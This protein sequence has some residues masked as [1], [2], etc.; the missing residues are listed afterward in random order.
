[1]SSSDVRASGTC[2]A[3]VAVWHT[4][5]PRPAA[6]APTTT[7]RTCG[8][9]GRVGGESVQASG[10]SAVASAAESA[11]RTQRETHGFRRPPCPPRSPRCPPPAPTVAEAARTRCRRCAPTLRRLRARARRRSARSTRCRAAHIRASARRRLLPGRR[12][13]RRQSEAQLGIRAHPLLQLAAV[14]HLDV[15]ATPQRTCLDRIGTLRRPI[16]AASVEQRRGDE[17]P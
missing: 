15:A 3:A 6:C 13:Q 11:S 1:M 5:P 9:A 14:R 8:L 10:R 7:K 12:Q 16:C 17:S 2:A 4:V